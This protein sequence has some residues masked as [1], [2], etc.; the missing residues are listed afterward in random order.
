MIRL[1]PTLVIATCL[2]AHAQPAGFKT[3]QETHAA[4]KQAKGDFLVF[5]GG[6]DWLPESAAVTKLLET[7]VTLAKLPQLAGTAFIPAAALAAEN[8][9][10][11]P[12]APDFTPYDLPS[13]SLVD[14]DGRT[15]AVTE[16]VNAANLSQAINSLA[17]ALPARARRDALFDKARSGN[18]IERARLLGRGLDEIPFRFSSR[19]T[20]ILAEIKAADPEDTC[21]YTFKYTFNPGGFHESVTQKMIGEKKQSELLALVDSHLKNPVLLSEQKQALLSA[22]MQV[23]RSL[24]D[25]PNAVAMLRQV[26]AINPKSELGTGAPDY[27]KLL[28][29]PVRLPRLAWEHD[30]NRPTW[31]PMV[32]DASARITEPGAYEIEFRHLGGHTRFRKVSL[33]SGGREIAGDPNTAESRKVRLTVPPAAK[34]KAIELWA[35][36]CGTGWFDGRGEIVITKVP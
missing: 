25:I 36:S 19:R 13:L 21:G 26:I 23:Y 4:A 15:F 32:A 30:D 33:K 11:L 14:P 31:L 18:G 22:K 17:S 35:E 16:G 9:K 27:I 8:V 3:Y 5:F 7:P 2:G 10:S 12:V 24:D 6:P 20:D 28:T 29:E 34:G 1:L